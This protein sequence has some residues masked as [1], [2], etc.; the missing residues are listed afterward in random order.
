MH[1]FD[2][3]QINLFCVSFFFFLFAVSILSG[4]GYRRVCTLLPLEA[5]FMLAQ[6][7]E[8]SYNGELGCQWTESPGIAHEKKCYLVRDNLWQHKRHKNN[9][10]SQ[11][12]REESSQPL[13]ELKLCVHVIWFVPKIMMWTYFSENVHMQILCHSFPFCSF[14]SY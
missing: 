11:N 8:R 13:L 4:K 5:F 6:K 1:S 12:K 2:N 10:I 9:Q 14:V 7:L 3:P